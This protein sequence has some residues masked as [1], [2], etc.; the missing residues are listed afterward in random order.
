MNG[1]LRNKALAALTDVTDAGR[2]LIYVQTPEED[3]VAALLRQAAV[4]A[5]KDR[6]GLFVWSVTE[7][8]LENDKAAKSQP[9]GPRGILDFVIGHGKPAIFLLK[10]YHDFLR[11]S[12]ELRRRLRD[13]YYDCL[14]TGKFVFISSPTKFI[15]QE[16]EREIAYV[17][18]PMPDLSEL[19]SL[20]T[21]EAKVLT[22]GSL[23]Q[24]TVYLLARALQGLSFNEARHA[25][26][27]GVAKTGRLDAETV[28]LVQEEKRLLVRKAGLME[29][30]PDTV[31]I[32]QLGGLDVMKQWLRQRRDLFYSRE[33]I[34]S[35]IVPKGVL[36]MG[37]SGCGK[38]LSA[39]VIANVFG[40]PLYRVDMSQV[41]A[42]GLGDA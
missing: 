9:E 10:D 38:S 40:L 2:P 36:M 24:E 11:D 27:Y 41:F 33:S 21:D 39:R 37:V 20:V 7:G 18:L 5:G 28:P 26:R 23:P 1:D 34:A 8:L 32:D 14:N 22:G 42:R 12:A 6:P 15:P 25:L 19:E 35:E 31:G 4:R 29:Y 17:K 16:I 3:R 13:V 30:V